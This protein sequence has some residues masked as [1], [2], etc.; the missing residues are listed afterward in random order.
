MTGER[1]YSFC[2]A[3]KIPI[4]PDGADRVVDTLRRGDVPNSQTLSG[5]VK[6]GAPLQFEG[7]DEITA[8]C[9]R[10]SHDRLFRLSAEREG[11]P[12]FRLVRDRRSNN[13]CLSW[14]WDLQDVRNLD[15]IDST[16][17][18]LRYLLRAC[19]VEMP[20]YSALNI[21]EQGKD[22]SRWYQLKVGGDTYLSLIP[23]EADLFPR[24][25]RSS[26]ERRIPSSYEYQPH[27]VLFN[28]S[29][30]GDVVSVLRA[31]RLAANEPIYSV[32]R[33]QALVKL[34]ETFI[35]S[36]SENRRASDGGD[37]GGNRTY[38]HDL[39][40][41]FAN[42]SN[43][44]SLRASTLCEVVGGWRGTAKERRDCFGASLGGIIPGWDEC[45]LVMRIDP[46][47]S[48]RPI[49]LLEWDQGGVDCYGGGRK[50]F[51]QI[52]KFLSCYARQST[53]ST[54][55]E[56]HVTGKLRAEMCQLPPDCHHLLYWPLQID[57][58]DVNIGWYSRQLQEGEVGLLEY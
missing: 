26:R 51:Y 7:V 5:R 25:I 54:K 15:A 1:F 41:E 39:L 53:A 22:S 29:N 10:L 58:S 45:Y 20:E 24:S 48:D 52:A 42:D 6:A 18:R 40:F 49:L 3:L 32:E 13:V 11:V 23:F 34:F 36:S 4:T 17:N 46:N 57:E 47:Q 55:H 12:D 14:D 50:A 16:W 38:L 8:G 33:E 19:D 37:E 56:E 30:I 31:L 43:P 28:S 21:T 27:Q 35:R 9:A 44:I 2:R